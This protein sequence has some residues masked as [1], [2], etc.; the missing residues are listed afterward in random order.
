MTTVKNSS[1]F[2]G[3]IDKLIIIFIWE[4]KVLKIVKKLWKKIQIWNI[5]TPPPV[6]RVLM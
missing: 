3:E 2:L 5:S 1:G 4:I 6:S